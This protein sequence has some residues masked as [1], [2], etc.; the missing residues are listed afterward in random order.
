[1]MRALRLQHK[2][3]RTREDR[4]QA[5]IGLVLALVVVLSAVSAQLVST[6]L[7]HDPL[8]QS[9]ALEHYAY[10]AVEAG[11]NDYLE[12]VNANPNLINC[13]VNNQSS[14][15][16]AGSGY[17]TW[18]Q[19]PGTAS[20]GSVVP[21][22]FLWNNPQLCFPTSC[23]GTS[24]TL[25]YATVLVEVAAGY[26][27]NFV[28]QSE[29]ADLDPENGFLTH[30]FWD[31][32]NAEPNSG[33]SASNC[34][35]DWAI[36]QGNSAAYNGPG[37]NCTPVYFGSSDSL[38]GP[39][40]S[41]DSIYVTGTPSFQSV[42]THDP[43]CLFVDNVAPS[44]PAY[45]CATTGPTYSASTSSDNAALEPI[46]TDDTE[47]AD[48]AARDGCLYSGPTTLSFSIV[49]G[50]AKMAVWSPDTPSSVSGQPT[51]GVNDGDNL[52][53][54]ANTCMPTSAGALVNAPEGSVGGNG[55]IYVENVPGKATCETGA[56]PFGD[57]GT[58][59][60]QY[61]LY[62]PDTS[63]GTY[64]CIGDVFVTDASQS[65]AGLT[66]PLTVAS[67]D[68]V[69]ITG[70]LQYSDCGSGFN[71]DLYGTA[72]TSA[73]HY[74]S[75]S[76]SVN[77]ALGL[78]AENYVEV[79]HPVNSNGLLSTCS[80]AQYG[81][82]SAA[83]CNPVTTPSASSG[84]GSCAGSASPAFSQPPSACDLTIDAAVLALNGTF[85]VNNYATGYEEGDLV[86]FGTIDEDWRGPVAQIDGYGFHGYAKNYTWDSRLGYVP[87]PSY[88]NPGTP[89]W[90][91]ISSGV[92]QVD[93]CVTQSAWPSGTLGTCS[94]LP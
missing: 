13:N 10:R 24:G 61:G 66:G 45:Q 43:D 78:I 91:L 32:Y 60:S 63:S 79:N 23:T 27:G 82:V 28:Y 70:N 7:Q 88:L 72:G 21:E 75:G 69:I 25:Q 26:P 49:S 65:V 86:A 3:R 17:G 89:S 19:V 38:Y 94:T 87:P 41:N 34:G 59:N 84:T 93:S 40:Y 85:T 73:C 90:S 77:D 20:G 80:S 55:V 9:Y 18:V 53:T 47:L 51:S 31:N 57:Y 71:S 6:V 39:L 8:V 35:Y 11:V 5:G 52:S 83:L 33:Y 37:E 58:T 48:V 29:N 68:D 62:L 92:S 14:G 22:Y 2:G 4:G 54:N 64:D 67:E 56:N 16:C 44:S 12:A 42:T 36:T 74:N 30:V 81:T 76:T 46:P 50:V 15:L 1:M